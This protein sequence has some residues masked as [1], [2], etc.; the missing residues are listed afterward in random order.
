MTTIVGITNTSLIALS[1]VVERAFSLD[2]LGAALVQAALSKDFAVVQG[3]SLVFAEMKRPVRDKLD[4]YKLTGKIEAKHFFP[5]VED[6]VTAY[7]RRTGADW[8]HPPRVL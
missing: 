1:A 6:A 4:R 7:Q 3:I 8:S 5:T 2:G